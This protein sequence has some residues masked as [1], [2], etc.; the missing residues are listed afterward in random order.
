VP[1][2][3][4]I[5][6]AGI[7]GLTV[8][9]ALLRH[10]HEVRV[11]EQAEALGEVG[12]GLTLTP[13]ATRVLDHLGLGSALERIGSTPARG[14]VLHWR[15]GAE[16]IENTRAATIAATYGAR[17]CQVHRADL[18][19]ML[20]AG[21]A[22]FAPHCI[23]LGARFDD[24][25]F[26]HGSVRSIFADGR[27]STADVLV[28]ADGLRSAVRDRLFGADTPR[29]SGYVAWR[30]LVP[31]A[32]LR[33]VPIEPPSA[34]SIGPGRIFTRYLL[35]RGR[36]LNYVGIVRTTGW[37]AEGWSVPGD[38][39]EMLAHFAGWHTAV[40]RTI[41]ATPPGHLHKWGLF[42][43][44][45]LSAWTRQRCT[46]LGD[47]AHPLLPFLG[48]GAALAIEDGCILARALSVGTSPLDALQR[49]QRARIERA[50]FV[51]AHSRAAGDRFQQIDTDNYAPAS[52]VS[53]FSLGLAAYDAVTVAI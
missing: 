5:I 39:A 25:R 6:G 33:A 4:D 19:E 35:R 42:H 37:Q 41:T 44:E 16:I 9:L 18:H 28:G 3:V 36:L 23:R 14:A 26:E 7:G 32:A 51:T 17:Y 21:T 10:G 38:A 53:A 34:M 46:L 50:R 40:T 24:V 29:F 15:T 31:M 12:A 45:P 8:A 49:Y 11:Y 27:E 43:R 22:R 47:A 48:Q 13:N 52:H 2:T 30:G 20:R 1:V